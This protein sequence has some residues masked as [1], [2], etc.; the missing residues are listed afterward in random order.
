MDANDGNSIILVVFKLR[1]QRF[2]TFISMSASAHFMIARTFT[3]EHYV[4]TSGGI[5]GCCSAF[6]LVSVIILKANNIVMVLLKG[7]SVDDMGCVMLTSQSHAFSLCRKRV[8][9]WTI[10]GSSWSRRINVTCRRM[11]PTMHRNFLLMEFFRALMWKLLQRRTL[12][13][14]AVL[15]VV[16]TVVSALTTWY[17]VAEEYCS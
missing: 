5:N 17:M 14:P 15:T 9:T 6:I 2:T 3:F 11:A 4:V 8:I 7:K 13:I 12:A 10:P 1:P 16:V